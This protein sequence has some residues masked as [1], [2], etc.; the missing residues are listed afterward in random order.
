MN[1]KKIGA[2]TLLISCSVLLSI[3]QVQPDPRT[4]VERQSIA[5]EKSAA[6][7]DNFATAAPKSSGIAAIATGNAEVFRNVYIGLGKS[8][9]LDSKLD[10]S[11][12]GSVAIG[13]QCI[14]CDTWANS[15]GTSGLVLQAQ[16]TVPEAGLYVT[17][18]NKAATTF[19]YWDS[20]GVIFS[21]YGS[22]FRL[23]LQNKGKQPISIEQITLLLRSN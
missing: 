19:L 6:S 23:I 12:A 2:A 21:G 22:K 17:T 13:F 3:A 5:M 9:S 15:L 7:H 4:T 11:F 1:I 18:E 16:W 14:V 10:Y 8:I 20:G